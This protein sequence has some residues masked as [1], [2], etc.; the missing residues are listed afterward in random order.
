MNQPDRE[1]FERIEEQQKE[2]VRRLDEIE[3]TRG[4]TEPIK[5]NRIETDTGGILERLTET[6]K[7]MRGI[8]E[9]QAGHGERLDTLSRGQQELRQELHTISNTWLDT[10]QEN[11]DDVKTMQADHSERFDRVGH[12]ISEVRQQSESRFDRIEAT[13]A[14]KD[15]ISGIKA[16]QDLILQLLQQKPGE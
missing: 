13:M 8:G 5:I 12:Q 10:L 9:R 3:R 16:T 1:R 6:N 7:L 4:E 2:I 11:F 14:T 15:D